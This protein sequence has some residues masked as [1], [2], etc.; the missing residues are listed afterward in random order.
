MF[1]EYCCRLVL[2]DDWERVS[3]VL[4]DAIKSKS[5]EEGVKFIRSMDVTLD[6]QESL[7]RCLLS[8]KRS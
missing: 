5:Y 6:K 8:H 3:K 1:T 4:D 7:E 2:G